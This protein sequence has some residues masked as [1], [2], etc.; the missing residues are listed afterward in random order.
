MK[1]TQRTYHSFKRFSCLLSL[2]TFLLVPI[3]GWAQVPDTLIR[4]LVNPN[5]S[6]Q[7]L[8][9]LGSSVAI[10]ELYTVVGAPEADVSKAGEGLVQVYDTATGAHVL[11]LHNPT[12]AVNDYFGCAVAVSGTRVVVGAEQN[13][14]QGNAGSAYVFDLAS[15]SPD[16]PILSLASAWS[17]D[18]F[19]HAVAISGDIVVVGSPLGGPWTA[20]AAYVY[21]LAGANPV[22]PIATLFDPSLLTYNGF[23]GAVAVNGN[24]VAVYGNA[25]SSATNQKYAGCVYIYDVTGTPILEINNPVPATNEWMGSAIALSG[26]LLVAGVHGKDIGG[27]TDA[28]SAYVFDVSGATPTVPIATLNNPSPISGEI[29]GSAVAISGRRIVIGA[30]GADLSGRFGRAF[31]YDLDSATPSTPLHTLLGSQ[32]NNK[33]GNSV[34]IHG[35]M[36]VVGE[37]FADYVVVDSGAAHLYDL[38]SATPTTRIALLNQLIP[39]SVGSFGYAVA[40][41]GTLVLVGAPTDETGGTAVGAAYLF[42]LA[43]GTPAV[44]IATFVGPMDDSRF[45]DVVAIDGDL[46]AVGAPTFRV[47]SVYPGRV[48][49]YSLTNA[50]PTLPKATLSRPGGTTVSSGFG[51]AIA[52]S[53][54]RVVVG[55]NSDGLGATYSGAA[56]VFDMNSSPPTTARYT[57]IQPNPV[58]SEGFGSAVAIVGTTVVVSATSE[59]TG[60]AN[61]GSAYIYNLGATTYNPA[62]RLTIRNPSAQANDHFGSALSLNGDRLAVGVPYD[63]SSGW[64]EAGL[65]YIYNLAGATPTTP[66][67]TLNRT[68]QNISE[69]FGLSVA[70]W[71]TQ[72]MVGAPGVRL[73]GQSYLYDLAGV[74]PTTVLA[75]PTNPVT[76]ARNEFGRTVSLCGTNAVVGSV[77]FVYVYVPGAP[78][79][80]APT[81]ISLSATSINEN[82]AANSTVGTLSTTDPDAGNTFTYTLIAG[83]GDTDNASFNI[84]GSSLRITASPNY[85]AKSSYSVRVRTTDQGS[86]TYEEAFTITINNVNETPTDIAL[87][88]SSINEN[89]A[90]NSTVG[91]LSTTDPDAGNTFVYALTNGTG[92]TD[93]NSFSISGSSLRTAEP[94][95]YEVKSN[96]TIRVQ[97]TDQGG[98]FTQKVFAIRVTDV[99]ETPVFYG[100][101]EPTNGNIVLRWSSTTNKL[102]TVHHSTNLLTGFSVLQS[103]IPATPAINSYTQSV[104]T[105]PQKFWKVTTDQ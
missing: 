40:M 78:I 99:D 91:T 92:S 14:T 50:N 33:Y 26:N 61:A 55:A 82:V 23:G 79:N 43:S 28:G 93:N 70:L 68:P 39:G 53:G 104:L 63:S 31:V 22:A 44:P 6:R 18:R 100:P 35:S 30:P 52:V 75:N 95:N 72:A 86:L 20:G 45:G 97:S 85:E 13:Y 7:R 59:D 62:P 42:D 88:P 64:G 3:T 102:Y 65:V 17:M 24:R 51:R 58:G 29:F 10:G 8:T 101:S 56:Y 105:V 36:F 19:G 96:Y 12:P 32:A 47:G 5:I 2:F 25:S 103:N 1:T 83:A 81:D 67:F 94:F 54:S 77:G 66:A 38:A 60:A 9:E 41:S 98:L 15:G 57:L 71:G 27:V 11:D 84:S 89:V 48:Y 49:V 80:N 37:P 4:T 69:R 34:A 46:I 16:T 73:C 21:N 90:A 74:P 76:A 87:S